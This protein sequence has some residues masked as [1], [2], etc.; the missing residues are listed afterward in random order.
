MS[1]ILIAIIAVGI[2]IPLIVVLIQLLLLRTWHLGDQPYSNLLMF[3]GLI[4]LS[5]GIGLMTVAFEVRKQNQKK[6]SKS[7]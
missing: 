3:L 1:P 4:P 6:N 5:F 7:A 2:N